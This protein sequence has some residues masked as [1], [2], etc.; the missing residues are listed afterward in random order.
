VGDSAESGGNETPNTAVTAEFTVGDR[1]RV[2]PGST[3]ERSGVVVEDFGQYAGYAVDVGNVHIVDAGRRWAVTLD[4][5]RLVFV[6]TPDLAPAQTLGGHRRRR[7]PRL[8]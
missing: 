6:D 5:G 7:W 4:D 8:R 2:Y 3:N 1:V